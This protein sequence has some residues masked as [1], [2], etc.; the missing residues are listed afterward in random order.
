VGA[1]NGNRSE[2]R[3]YIYGKRRLR[4]ILEQ[5]EVLEIRR[6]AAVGETG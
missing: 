3:D 5:L 4:E 6:G 2:N 1:A